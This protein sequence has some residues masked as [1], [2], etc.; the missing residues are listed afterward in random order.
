MS[1]TVP[2]HKFHEP[3]RTNASG[4]SISPEKI[5]IGNRIVAAVVSW[6]RWPGSGTCQ[7]LPFAVGGK[8]MSPSTTE[9]TWAGSSPN[10][11]S[12]CAIS[13]SI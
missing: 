5:L 10:E 13:A 3:A 12:A 9:S 8:G 2:L 11:T 1:R 4:S 7:V 6:L